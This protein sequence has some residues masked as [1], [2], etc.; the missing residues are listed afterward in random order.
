MAARLRCYRHYA[1]LAAQASKEALREATNRAP[2]WGARWV[3]WMDVQRTA[4]GVARRDAKR[5]ARAKAAADAT[6]F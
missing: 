6:H 2:G 1:G 4:A 5:Y 3:Y